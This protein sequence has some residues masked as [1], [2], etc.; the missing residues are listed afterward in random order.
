MCCTSVCNSKLILLVYTP[1]FNINLLEVFVKAIFSECLKIQIVRDKSKR[2]VL[3]IYFCIKCQIKFII[4][5][6]YSCFVFYN[7]LLCLF[8]VYHVFVLFRLDCLPFNKKIKKHF[9]VIDS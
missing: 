1:T 6:S 9:V 5:A 7:L 2:M 8:C 4:G 3:Q